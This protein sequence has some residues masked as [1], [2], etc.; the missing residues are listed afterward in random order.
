MT[1]QAALAEVLLVGLPLLLLGAGVLACAYY[2]I[3]PRTLAKTD[4]L[5]EELVADSLDQ[6]VAQLR[7]A[8]P[9]PVARAA[10]MS[11][12]PAMAVSRQPESAAPSFTDM[13]AS[14]VAT[15]ALPFLQGPTLSMAVHQLLNEGLSDRSIAR[16]LAVG[17]EEVR[18]A[19]RSS[20]T[21]RRAA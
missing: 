15:P 9:P 12:A 7:E 2:V 3:R 19:R 6:L 20:A 18:A 11:L 17:I 13:P 21:S 16:R 5:I 4:R 14:A 8:Q 1:L 10:S